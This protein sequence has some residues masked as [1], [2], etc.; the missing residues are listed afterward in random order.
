MPLVI[1]HGIAAEAVTKW[2]L[3]PLV[4]L[5]LLVTAAM[6]AFGVGRLWRR[7]GTGRGIPRWSVAA[8][9]A[10]WL[11]LVIA[12]VSPVAWLS[13]ILFSVHMTQH[14]LLMLVAAPLLTFAQP[15]LAWL[16]AFGAETRDRLAAPVRG[17]R[18]LAAWHVVT[19]PLA[20]FLLQTAALWLWH[21]P[22]W[23][24][25]ALRNDAIHALEHLTLV[26]TG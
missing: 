17:R 7:A 19:A 5:P 15:L 13:E 1:A 22:A 9:G 26:V 20:V 10:G 8:F 23:Y 18:F 4:L 25:A 24:E 11:T 16:W 21:I 12:L 6:Y 2:D 3:D 14:T